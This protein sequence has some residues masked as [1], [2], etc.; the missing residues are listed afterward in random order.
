MRSSRPLN[1]SVVQTVAILPVKRLALAKQRLGPGVGDPFRQRLARAMAADVLSALSRAR[2]VA[3]TIVVTSEAGVASDARAH[4]ALVLDDVTEAGQS[5]AVSLGIAR[6]LDEG[7]GRVLCVPGDCPALEPD[8][9]DGLLERCDERRTASRPEVVIVP[10]RHGT[11]TNGLLL[12]P[13]DVIAPSFGPGSC[14][15][16]RLLAQSAGADW[17]LERLPSL[18]LDIDTGDDLRA[19]RGSLSGAR[20]SAIRTRSVLDQQQGIPVLSSATSG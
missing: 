19:L 17:R 11:G 15:R 1:L 4:G 13:P 10:D 9:L 14:E 12:S 16:H 20:A 18:L 8:E 3:Q 7:C 2:L 5:A 6:A